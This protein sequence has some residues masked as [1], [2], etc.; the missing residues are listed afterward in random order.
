MLGMVPLPG[1]GEEKE[2]P[3]FVEDVNRSLKGIYDDVRRKLNE[4]HQRNKFKYD[5]KV[6]GGN[7]TVGDRVWLYVPAMKQGRTR[8][9]S[10]L[11]RGPYTIID[12][13]G[14][15][16]Y[17]IQLIGSSKTLVVHRNRLKLCYGEPQSKAS[18]KQPTPAPQKRL[19]ETAYPNPTSPP[20]TQV[21]KLTHEEVVAN[22]QET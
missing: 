14:A 1:E 3:E 20:T 15:V 7:L 9:L 12:R 17:R 11:W 8:K 4:A 6:A 19:C 18:K 21:S 5:E 10:S 22:K 13:V 16:T 2:I